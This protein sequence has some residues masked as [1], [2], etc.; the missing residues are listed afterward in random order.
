MGC[1]VLAFFKIDDGI[2]YGGKSSEDEE[3]NK[4]IAGGELLGIQLLGCLMIVLW[5]GGLSAIFFA[6]S[7]KMNALRLSE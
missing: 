3:G 5:S 1:V 4:T 2:F 7:M 6:V